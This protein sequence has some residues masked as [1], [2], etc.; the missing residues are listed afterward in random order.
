MIE[1]M[2][3]R[4]VPLALEKLK[5]IS[6][7]DMRLYAILIG[8]LAIAVETDDRAYFERKLALVSIPD[9]WKTA[10]IGAIWPDNGNQT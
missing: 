10:L 4:V 1:K 6:K 2:L 5:G 7:Q 9:T 3:E 8:D